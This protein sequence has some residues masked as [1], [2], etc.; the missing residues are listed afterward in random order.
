MK[1]PTRRIAVN[2]GG[3]YVPGL[4]AVITE[5]VLAASELGW[6]V[7]GIRDDHGPDDRRRWRLVDRFRRGYAGRGAE[8][9]GSDESRRQALSTNSD[10]R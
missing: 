8:E 6:E 1:I 9:N 7:L 10:I 2:V 4:N 3:G 5:V